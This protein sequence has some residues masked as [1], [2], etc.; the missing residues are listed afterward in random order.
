M[1]DDS[2]NIIIKKIKKSHGGAHGG[3]WKVAYADF[4]TAMMAFFL[5]LWL[6]SMVSEEKKAVMSDYFT[7]FNLFDK[8]G[9]SFTMDSSKI[10]L[11]PGKQSKDIEIFMRDPTNP[12]EEELKKEALAKEV[13]KAVQE[14][15]K[16]GKD[17]V[18]VD[19]FEGGVRIQIVDK[20]A[21]PMFPLGSAVPNPR[22]KEILRVVAETLKNSSSKIAVE[23][24]TDST[25]F[26]GGGQITN[27][28]LSTGR[29]SAARIELEKCGIPSSKIARVVGYADTELLI[30]DNP[31]D[32]RN[33]RMSIIVLGG[34]PVAQAAP[35]PDEDKAAKEEP[36][37]PPA[38]EEQT[39]VQ[40]PVNGLK[41]KV[42][43]PG[44]EAGTEPSN[45]THA[46]VPT[47]GSKP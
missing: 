5:L 34:V 7:R 23:G 26:R 6:L 4:V 22:A 27:W 47:N 2:K 20:D 38:K 45:T 16:E 28:E 18:L 37:A 12:E 43:P 1:A 9:Q 24:H 15:L 14:K 25:P 3:S 19:A 35:K 46:D 10:G 17:Q 21:T 13:K 39:P 41:F 29:A 44:Q 30:K 40:E 32:A 42:N 31:M 36:A 8:T 33:R 11:I